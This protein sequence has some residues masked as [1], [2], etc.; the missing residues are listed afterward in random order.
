MLNSIVG[1]WNGDGN[2][3]HGYKNSLSLLPGSFVYILINNSWVFTATPLAGQRENDPA[4]KTFYMLGLLLAT[5]AVVL[6]IGLHLDHSRS[7][8]LNREAVTETS[9]LTI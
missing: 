9:N 8:R 7:E 4:A 2:K 5:A 3:W 1:L 6:P